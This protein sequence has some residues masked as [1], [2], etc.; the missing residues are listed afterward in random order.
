M[1]PE[2][3]KRRALPRGVFDAPAVKRYFTPATSNE[4]ATS[5]KIGL[6]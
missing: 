3:R 6:L 5:M 2:K 4:P 1:H